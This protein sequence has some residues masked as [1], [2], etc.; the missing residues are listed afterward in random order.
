MP[1]FNVTNPKIPEWKK[2]LFPCEGDDHHWLMIEW[3]DDHEFQD[4]HPIL[5]V[6][7]TYYADTIWG[8]IKGAAKVLFGRRHFFG[9]I[10]LDAETV[11]RLVEI[12]HSHPKFSGSVNP[13]PS[14]AVEDN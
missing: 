14:P 3:W 11:D 9:G 8:R 12:I 1:V 13:N 6:T 10:I 7:E 4:E 5:E 2:H